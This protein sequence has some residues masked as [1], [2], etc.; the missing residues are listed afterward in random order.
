M[1]FRN[2]APNMK[3]IYNTNPGFVNLKLYW[4]LSHQATELFRKANFLKAANASV[5]SKSTTWHDE[6]KCADSVIS[7]CRKKAYNSESLSSGPNNCSN[8]QIC[9]NA[10]LLVCMHLVP[11]WIAHLLEWFSTT[12]AVLCWHATLKPYFKPMVR[13]HYVPIVRI[14]IVIY[15]S[16]SSQFAPFLSLHSHAHGILVS[17]LGIPDVVCRLYC[18]VHTFRPLWSIKQCAIRVAFVVKSIQWIVFRVLSVPKR[19]GKKFFWL[20]YSNV[21]LF[22]SAEH[23]HQQ[24]PFGMKQ[25]FLSETFFRQVSRRNGQLHVLCPHFISAPFP[26]QNDIAPSW[27]SCTLFCRGIWN[28]HSITLHVLF[29]RLH[30]G[31]CQINVSSSSNALHQDGFTW[32]TD[33][34]VL[35]DLV[36]LLKHQWSCSVCT[37]CCHKHLSITCNV[38]SLPAAASLFFDKWLPALSF[39]FLKSRLLFVYI[40]S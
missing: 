4:E 36:K 15:F 32:L 22:S 27:L 8:M 16:E 5:N 6:E 21:E 23:L 2:R 25:K 39:N 37:Q 3:Q 14:V 35:R 40:Y 38:I 1:T 10:A 20:L 29:Q 12:Q 11:W 24:M 13:L 9:I 30:F 17:S 31:P 26:Y 28:L 33:S 19:K 7:N 34:E 18:Y